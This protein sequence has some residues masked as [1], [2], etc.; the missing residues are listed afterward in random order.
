MKPAGAA[1]ALASPMVCRRVPRSGGARG[2]W[3]RPHRP[4]R[5][6]GGSILFATLVV[7]VGHTF[8]DY[9]ISNDEEVQ[10]HYGEL[11]VAYYRSGF[12][13]QAVF[14]FRN[15]YLYG[16]L[17]DIAAVG[18]EKLVPLDPYA[19]RH[20]LSALTGIGG[21]AAVWATARTIAG[22]RAGP[23][24]GRD[25]RRVRH[26]V[27]YDVQSHQGH[28]VRGRDDGRDLFS[29]A[30]RTGAAAA[31]LASR[32][33]V[34]RVLRRRARDSRARR[35]SGRLRRARRRAAGADRPRIVARGRRLWRPFGA[36][37][38][39]GFRARLRDH[40]RCVAVGG[41]GA[42][43]SVARDLRIHGFPLQDPTV[44]DGRVYYMSDVPRWYVPTYMAIK[45][46]LC[47]ARRRGRLSLV[48]AILPQRTAQ[49]A[50]QGRRQICVAKGNGACRV[51]GIPAADL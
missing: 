39:R 7:L 46:T 50:E 34:R 40:D 10:Q 13:D 45:L 16:G 23:V 24:G 22:P 30:D 35:V 26:L 51:R 20:I 28:P 1:G 14:H 18:L 42:A 32:G 44:L 5:P 21:L 37:V 15:L 31:A 41:L 25:A 11:I 33:A 36:A 19:V 9:A 47:A 27:R 8:G 49:P 12:I 43:Q 17:F 3:A 2:A 29:G 48:L 4:L 38:R 6:D